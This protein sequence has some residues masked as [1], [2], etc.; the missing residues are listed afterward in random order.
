ME[1]KKFEDA[2]KRPAGTQSVKFEPIKAELELKD[3]LPVSNVDGVSPQPETHSFQLQTI[4]KDATPERLESSVDKG[5]K[6]LDQ[7]KDQM[8]DKVEDTVDA[9]QWIEQIGMYCV[10]CQDE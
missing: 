3:V 5:V 7:L 10:S 4:L 2:A 9:G 8:R 1:R 6:L